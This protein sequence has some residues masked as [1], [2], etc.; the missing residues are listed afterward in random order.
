MA[1]EEKSMARGPGRRWLKAALGTAG[2]ALGGFL[3]YLGV[4]C[5]RGG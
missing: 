2:G 4:G 1:E 3:I 5:L